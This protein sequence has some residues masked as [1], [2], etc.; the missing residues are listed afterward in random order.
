MKK[1]LYVLFILLISSWNLSAQSVKITQNDLTGISLNIHLGE[2]ES[3]DFITS[4]ETFSRIHL[5]GFLASNQVGNP[6]LPVMVKM[7]EIPLC[8][9]VEITATAGRVK[10]YPGSS[11]G[12]QHRLYPAQRSISKSE[13]GPFP[14]Q[15]NETTYQTDE[16]YGVELAS[17]EKTGI[18][19]SYN[20]ATIY[21][22]PI[23]YNPVTNEFIVYDDI[24]VDI[25]YKNADIQAT[26]EMKRIH[27]SSV[28]GKPSQIIN[29]LPLMSREMFPASPVKYVIVAN[30]MFNG[31]L[32]SLVNWKKRKGFLVEVAYTGTIGT[33]TTAIKNYLQGLYDNATFENPAPTYVLLVGDV[34]QIPAHNGQSSS[35]HITDLY[36]FTWTGNDNIPDCYYG[37]FSAQNVSQLTPQI[38]KTLIY[39]QYAMEDPS[40]LDRALLAA[41]EDQGRQGD[42]GY[43]HAD[44]A[45]HYLEDNYANSTYGYTTVT[46]YYNPHSNASTT[47]V[48]NALNNGVGYA[49]YSAHCSSSGWATPSFTTS[50]ANS[51]T[52]TGK[53]GL[54]IGNCC[55]SNSFNESQCFGEALLR[56]NNTGAVGYIGGTDYTYWDEDYWWAVGVRS[57]STSCSNCNVASYDANNLGAYDKLFHTHGENFTNWYAT[58]GSMIIGGNIAV[59]SS[60]SSLKQYYWEIYSLMGD[61][62]V[63]PW[64]TR[65]DDM[66]IQID[67]NAITDNEYRP[68][69]GT[70]SF[71]ISTG[72]PHTYIALTQNLQLIHAVLSDANGNATLTFPALH[73]GDTYELAASAQNYK[74]TFV[75]IHPETQ[76]GARVKITQVEPSQQAAPAAETSITLDV[77]ISNN[78]PEAA[79][80]TFITAT[81]E[82]TAITLTDASENAGTVGAYAIDTLWA[83][84]AL[85]IGDV[86]NN[87]VAPIQ[88]M[89]T[90]LDNGVADTTYYTYN[91][92]I[93]APEIDF[94]NATI[95]EISGNNN[96][97]VEP[98][99]TISLSI[100][101]QNVGG[102]AA[103][104]LASLLSTYY[105][106]S[107][108]VNDS[109]NFN[110]LNNQETCTSSFTIQI[111]N[112]VPLGTIIPFYHHIYSLDNPT[113]SRMDTV[114][115]IV[116]TVS[117][118][119]DWENNNFTTNDWVNNSTYRWTIVNSGAY[120]GT[121]C[122]KS[123][124]SNRGNSSSDLSLTIQANMDG[125]ISYF[126]KVSSEE[127][128]DFFKAYLD[129]ELI[130]TLSGTVDWGEFSVPVTAGEHTIRFS[131]TKDRYVNTGSDCAWVDN[132]SWPTNGIVAPHV[133]D[134]HIVNAQM[135]PNSSPVAGATITFDATLENRGD[136]ASSTVNL[137]LSTTSTDITLTDA[138]ETVTSVSTLNPTILTNAFAGTV[139]PDLENDAIADFTL[140]A[141]YTD[142]GINRTD[143][144]NFSVNIIASFMPVIAVA[145]NFNDSICTSHTSQLVI[146][147]V[148]GTDETPTF[149]WY[150]DGQP[151]TNETLTSLNIE[152]LPAGAYNF[153]V[154][155]TLNNEYR[156]SASITL[157]VLETPQLTISGD[158]S[159][160]ENAS[161][162]LTAQ[163]TSGN[164]Y[165]YQ[166]YMNSNEIDGATEGTYTTNSA[167]A[168]GSYDYNLKAWNN[169]FYDECQLTA[170]YTVN[171][172]SAPT[173]SSLTSNSSDGNVC[174]YEPFTLTATSDATESTY[175]WSRNGNTITETGASYTDNLTQTGSVE[176]EVSVSDGNC[177][178]APV[179]LTITAQG[180]PSATLTVN[181]EN[182]YFCA[183]NEAPTITLE[184]ALT[185][186]APFHFELY[187]PSDNT[188]TEYSSDNDSY[189]MT[190]IP[191]ATTTTYQLTNLSDQYCAASES[192]VDSITIFASSFIIAEDNIIIDYNG[193][194]VPYISLFFIN[195]NSNDP[196]TTISYT[197]DDY[198]HIGF[199]N[200]TGTLYVNRTIANTDIVMPTTERGTYQFAIIIDGC[201][202][203][204][205]V[206]I[207][208]TGLMENTYSSLLLYPNPTSNTVTLSFKESLPQN[209][210]YFLYDMYGKLVKS[211]DISQQQTTLSLAEYS[212]G[213]YFI[214]VVSEQKILVREKII[215]K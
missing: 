26:K 184:L 159:V 101:D 50:N 55:Q 59:E 160:C 92:T 100:T 63:L 171:V 13:E 156:N 61:P 174:L 185:G 97:I 103:T 6:E 52:N 78:Y 182:Q 9:D 169:I 128:Y 167:L 72:A 192:I 131:Y 94:V 133:A 5:D 85:S 187:N 60:N 207:I 209:A 90:Y 51:M 22:S 144:F 20:L 143:T 46:A 123:G 118:T 122:A 21:I 16:F 189:N 175:H 86:P 136:T 43:S 84:F 64:L 45:M 83:S 98:G 150:R 1:V 120:A 102:L 135:S 108:I 91:L 10:T 134:V 68:E 65:P 107:P 3:N 67:G 42:F 47:G 180:L 124:N 205:T 178:S 53:F 146:A 7:I 75:T 177:S 110:T 193:G 129:G 121:Y 140:I 41:G 188:S 191:T 71:T 28:F 168:E 37:R 157:Y 69:D 141:S 137:T 80:N 105:I 8:E 54:M 70:T 201:S 58:Q 88:F 213:I 76:A 152:N 183:D 19:R 125:N 212:S 77:M 166:W 194:G 14:I 32:D 17:I 215:K 206:T 44:P 74:T 33:T 202:Y 18:M 214:Q 11:L 95:Q 195:Q 116:G 23:K 62:S 57:L 130:E 172:T 161:S 104:N 132:I 24:D 162:L 79:T 153:Y 114:F 145:E 40:Y 4:G 163:V 96:S 154:Q 210:Q 170:N 151:L 25:T 113:I 81:T 115:V 197:I 126:R 196:R 2:I 158:A 39:E 73:E 200:T 109:L 142:N 111:G 149:Q 29:Q 38:E 35:S 93:V 49:N 186:T 119:E 208:S 34:A 56:A 48:R 147:E 165:Q 31:Q 138:T 87:T 106:Y 30:D 181:A 164:N 127:D 190:I 176:Y 12:I 15:I 173:I 199:T 36:Y 112:E 204:V 117:A 82:S 139:N 148:L 155:A 203:D 179:Q 198:N 66:Q 27:T 211:G 89:V 99:E